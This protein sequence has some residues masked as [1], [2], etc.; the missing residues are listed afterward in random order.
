MKYSEEN[1]LKIKKLRRI[2]YPLTSY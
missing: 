1:N 2:I